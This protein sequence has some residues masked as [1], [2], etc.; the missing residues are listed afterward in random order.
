MSGDRLFI[1]Y[2]DQLLHDAAELHVR[3]PIFQ[4]PSPPL[5]EE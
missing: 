2:S 3:W 1:L 4:D 5:A